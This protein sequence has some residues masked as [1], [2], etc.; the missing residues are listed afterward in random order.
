MVAIAPV[1]VLPSPVAISATSPLSRARVPWS[2]TSKGAM[3]RV[4]RDLPEDGEQLRD[5]LDAAIHPL[6]CLADRVC[7]GGA[8]FIVGG[9]GEA[10]G[11]GLC[12][13]RPGLLLI[14]L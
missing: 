11:V 6:P 14:L 2:W 8:E 3:P 1:R 7:R 5:V 12:D 4:R 9:A 10:L 13:D